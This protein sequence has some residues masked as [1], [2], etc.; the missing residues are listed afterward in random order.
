MSAINPDKGLANGSCNRRDCQAPLADEPTHQFM[1][2]IFTGGP[3]LHYC[4]ECSERFDRDDRLFGDAMRIE[5]EP[6]NQEV[7]P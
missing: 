5:R 7:K 1:H 4:A 6:K 2:G 3:R